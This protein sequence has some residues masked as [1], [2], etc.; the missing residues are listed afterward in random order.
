[1]RRS[2]SAGALVL[3]M[4]LG[5]ASGVLAANSALRPAGS[6]ARA[7]ALVAPTTSHVWQATAGTTGFHG[8][9]RLVIS[10][11]YSGGTA[12]VIAHGIKKGDRVLATIAFR[13]AKGKLTRVVSHLMTITVVKSG[14][15]SFAFKL[16][17]AEAH[18][19]RAAITAGDNLSFHLRDGS[20][21][22]SAPYVKVA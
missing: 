7:H 15:A 21:R 2:A 10:A 8:S 1:M 18:A 6:Q 22:I 9:S 4:S 19:V 11:T 20:A 13:K 5:M 17:T 14:T 12:H 16:T 3:I